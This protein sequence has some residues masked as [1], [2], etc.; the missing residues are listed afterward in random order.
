MTHD[1]VSDLQKADEGFKGTMCEERES[2]DGD[3][4]LEILASVCAGGCDL[5]KGR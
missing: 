2:R 5:V 4:W 3:S 1:D